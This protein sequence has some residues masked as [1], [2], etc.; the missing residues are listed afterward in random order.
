MAKGIW[1]QYEKKTK[2]TMNYSM[3]AFNLGAHGQQNLKTPFKMSLHEIVKNCFLES[4]SWFTMVNI[5]KYFLY[6]S[7]EFI[8]CTFI[9]EFLEIKFFELL[10]PSR[11]SVQGQKRSNFGFLTFKYALKN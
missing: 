7:G 1:G 10:R 5:Y 4:K 9:F 3:K 6:E 2:N 11:T 8:V